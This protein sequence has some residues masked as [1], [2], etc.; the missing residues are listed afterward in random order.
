[1][2]I[3]MYTL[4]NLLVPVFNFRSQRVLENNGEYHYWNLSTKLAIKLQIGEMLIEKLRRGGGRRLRWWLLFKEHIFI[5]GRFCLQSR[6][7]K[8]IFSMT[9]KLIVTYELYH[10]P[11][12]EMQHIVLFPAP[13]LSVC[14][15][16][17]IHVCQSFN[18]VLKFNADSKCFLFIQVRECLPLRFPA[19]LKRNFLRLVSTS[20]RVNLI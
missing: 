10:I 5:C 18:D 13:I 6:Y 9:R 8:C 20:L 1:M 16:R 17:L 12:S 19:H 7:I 2:Y 3:Y 14:C 15:L 11:N 4:D